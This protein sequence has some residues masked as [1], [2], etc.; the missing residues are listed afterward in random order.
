MALK[1]KRLCKAA[2]HSLKNKTW[3]EFD[4]GF[5]T[6]KLGMGFLY[7]YA[8]F[9][10]DAAAK[11]QLDL[12]NSTLTNLFQVRDFRL[13][14]AG[15]LNTK[16]QITWK[17]GFMY[18]GQIRTWFVRESGVL[19]SVPELWGSFFIGRTKEGISMSK[20]MNGY[21]VVDG[22]ERATVLDPIPILADGIKWMGYLPTPRIFWNAGVYTDLLSK[23]QGFSTYS[24]QTTLRAG[25]LPVHD[26]NSNLHI[27]FAFRIGHPLDDAIQSQ[28]QARSRSCPLLFEHR[29]ISSRSVY[30][31]GTG[32]L[33]QYRSLANGCG[34]LLGQFQLSH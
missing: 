29:H 31:Q 8:G 20:V 10:Q 18:D 5:T 32:S 14:V 11:Q 6:L 4:L 26:A 21:S 19:I 13:L 24:W 2:A 33:L 3:N 28:V 30:L 12:S 16:R 22:L 25:W 27:A 23:G 17:G 34:I 15:Q 7:E 1:A 9:S